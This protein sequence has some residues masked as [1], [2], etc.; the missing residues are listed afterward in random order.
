MNFKIISIELTRVDIVI[1]VLIERLNRAL[2]KDK[3]EK[4][5]EEYSKIPNLVSRVWQL[6]DKKER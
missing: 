3:K 6:Y 1:F 2:D 5:D 4:G